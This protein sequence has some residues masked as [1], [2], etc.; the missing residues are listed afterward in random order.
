MPDARLEVTDGLGR[1]IVPIDKSKFTLG[2]RETNDLRLQGAEV[3][4][5]HAV[6]FREDD[7]FHVE[8]LK[9]RYGTFVNDAEITDALEHG[10]QI[11]L[12]RGGGAEIVFLV[13]DAE[14]EPERNTTTAVTDLRHIAALLEGMHA[15]GSGRVLD[16]VLSLVMDSA[17][18]VS[19]AERGF[20]ML[21]NDEGT[22]EFKLGRGRD[23]AALAGAKFETSRKIPEEVFETGESRIV[24]DLMDGDLANVHMGT[25]AL[26]IRNVHCVPLKLVR[27]VDEVR[28]AEEQRRIS[29]LY[30]DSREKGALMSVS[31]RTA[32]ETLATEGA[33]HRER[34]AVPHD[35]G[36]SEAGSGDADRR[37][38]SAGALAARSADGDTFRSGRVDGGVPVDRRRFL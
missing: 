12:G 30:L 21:A 1:R 7:G 2:R 37:R 6:I 35:A 36:E 4:R 8:D 32:L 9:S 10:D 13:R 19:G 3:S 28:Q 16:D 22:L 15:L 20:I 14:E 31:T 33:R 17:I 18:T 27:Y 5:D 34:Q 23:R 38:D 11:R 24:A 25:V 29:V 26:G